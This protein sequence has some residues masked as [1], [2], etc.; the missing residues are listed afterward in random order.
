MTFVTKKYKI[1]A[2]KVIFRRKQM[3]TEKFSKP[4]YDTV[5]LLERE[6]L[7]RRFLPYSVG[8]P[9]ECY[10]HDDQYAR[11]NLVVFTD[12]HTDFVN[13]EESL[14]NARRTIEFANTCPV[15]ID[16]MVHTGD[17]ITPFGVHSK[18]ASLARAEKFFSLARQSDVP[19]LFSKGNHDLNDWNNYPENVFTDTDWG[20]LFLDFAE[21]NYGICRQ[22]KKNGQK[23]T[24]HYLDIEDKK[25]RIISVDVQ[26]TDKVTV[27]EKGTV[28]YYGA[29]SIYITD[30][31]IRWI[32][33]TAL[34]FSDKAEKDWGV[35]FAFHQT[36]HNDPGYQNTVDELIH[37]AAA[38][39]T[40]EK[41]S[42]HFVF[43][44]NHFFDWNIDADFSY[45]NEYTEKPHIICCIVGHNHID[46][47]EMREGI[48]V[49]WSLHA[50]CT[51]Q[52]SD[53]RYARIPGTCTQNSFSI[54]NIDTQKRKIRIFRY[55]AGVNCYGAGGDRFLPDG[56][57]Y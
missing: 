50:A 26:D 1:V 2:N 21:Q 46:A 31:Q 40:Q 41:Y 54:F 45:Y 34:N 42:K 47:H 20:H 17:I 18:D 27:N 35:I 11:A 8:S 32:A 12:S 30:E 9:K 37:L 6:N 51:T 13:P 29:L 15:R 55:G 33:E 39:N 3:A 57:S 14:D 56:L 4:D 10:T 19:L 48:N 36:S 25:I 43:E 44:E 53:A 7:L 5:C 16:A 28:K 23:S 24:W 49:I 52:S 38:F 22:N